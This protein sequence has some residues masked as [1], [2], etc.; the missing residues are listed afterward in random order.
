MV[1]RFDPGGRRISDRRPADADPDTAD[2]GNLC[3]D[4]HLAWCRCDTRDTARNGDL[5]AQYRGPDPGDGGHFR[6]RCR[7]SAPCAPVGDGQFLSCGSAGRHVASPGA[8]R[9]ARWR[10]SGDRYRAKY[11]RCRDCR[12]PSGRPVTARTCRPCGAENWRP[13]QPRCARRVGHP[14]CGIDRSLRSSPIESAF[15]AGCS[16]APCSPPRSCTAADLSMR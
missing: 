9:R 1:V 16:S 5:S 4:R 10:P 15:R 7:V 12:R 8:R 13:A 6:R 2:A 14:S 11:P 3:A